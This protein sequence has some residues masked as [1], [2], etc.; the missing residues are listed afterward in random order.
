MSHDRPSCRGFEPERLAGGGAGH[1]QLFDDRF[2]LASP[3]ELKINYNFP[4]CATH[5]RLGMTGFSNVPT[6]YMQLRQH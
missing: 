3:Q 4:A 5:V 1:A 2:V 6:F